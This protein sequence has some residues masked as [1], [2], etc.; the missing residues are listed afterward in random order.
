MQKIEDKT[1]RNHVRDLAVEIIKLTPWSHAYEQEREKVK[2][3]DDMKRIVALVKKHATI[4]NVKPGQNQLFQD[5]Y[6]RFILKGGLPSLL[7]GTIPPDVFSSDED[8]V[9]LTAYEGI[10]LLY[11]DRKITGNAIDT[12]IELFEKNDDSY[13]LHAL[14]NLLNI[15][16]IS[17]PE[18]KQY[19]APAYYDRFMRALKRSYMQD[20][21]WLQKTWLYIT[22]GEISDEKL[23]KIRRQKRLQ[24][25]EKLRRL[26]GNR[27]RKDR[28]AAKQE[29]RELAQ[30]RM[31]KG[32]GVR[33]AREDWDLFKE[34]KG[35]VDKCWEQKRYPQDADLLEAIDA[36]KSQ[37][38]KGLLDLAKSGASGY[39]SLVRIPMA[40]GETVYITQEYLENSRGEILKQCQETLKEMEDAENDLVGL[41]PEIQYKRTEVLHGIIQFLQKDS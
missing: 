38:A 29:V 39:S 25:D 8:I 1:Q 20:L 32:A 5:K 24:T 2:T 22:G 14:E 17:E 30:K 13:L 10:F 28:Q 41:D 7:S 12:A 27:H 3:R 11:R 4:Y 31:Q 15:G 33:Y 21:G 16:R 37:A 9:D 34:M 35:I 23:S 18:L 19:V 6:L 26:K 40:S 36:G